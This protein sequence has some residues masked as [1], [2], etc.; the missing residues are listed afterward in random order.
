MV[1]ENDSVYVDWQLQLKIQVTVFGL[2]FLLVHWKLKVILN[3]FD[4]L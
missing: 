2:S 3:I 1:R 4:P